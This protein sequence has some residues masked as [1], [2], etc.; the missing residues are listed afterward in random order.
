MY[1]SPLPAQPPHANDF[2]ATCRRIALLTALFLVHASAVQAQVVDYV[3]KPGDNPWDFARQHLNP[4]LVDTLI[5]YNGIKDP[6]HIPPGTVIRIPDSWL[7]RGSRQV[8]VLDVAGEASRVIGKENVVPLKAGERIPAR[9]RILTSSQGSVTL[10]FSDG[11]RMLIREHS[12]VRLQ[13]NKFVPLA[14]GR[15]IRINIP[16]GK[17]ESDVSKH[18]TAP[19]RFEIQ[20]PSGV[21][22]VRGTQ[23]RVASL[24]NETRT[25]VL[26]GKV[27]VGNKRGVFTGLPSGFG[28]SMQKG[29]G[30]GI[31]PLLKAPHIS[32]GTLLVERLPIDLP[33]SPVDGA[34]GYRTLLS[35][36][37]R[38]SA[39]FSDQRR[40]IAA[41]RISDVPDG[42]YELRVRAID[43][44]ELEGEELVRPIT[45]NA[46]PG[47]PF[48][49]APAAEA[50]LSATRPVFT[51][52]RNAEAASYRFQLASNVEFTPL[53]I[54]EPGLTESKYQ[55]GNDLV[56]GR[57][58][59]RPATIS[60]NEG[61]G[62]YSSPDTFLRTPASPGNVGFS[63]DQQSLRWQR[64]ANARYRVQIG[65]A[66][67]IE[68]PLI[69]TVLEQNTLSMTTLDAGNY[70]VRIQTLSESGLT[71]QWTEVQSFT[72]ESR[73][74]WRYLLLPLP[75]LLI[76]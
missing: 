9:S 76:L 55:P 62:P 50:S 61:Q 10:Q 31:I 66:A 40:D 70:F 2:R 46:R 12:D 36:S 44:H 21:A 73:F 30:N 72:V 45:I 57:Y 23:F 39:I 41:M 43:S 24:A 25:E 27:A 22:A 75:F 38:S 51:W 34:K 54:D 3:I 49:I 65:T 13:T 35:A 1:F 19:G 58:Y 56:E 5:E 8:T 11:S 37:A 63:S 59:W 64:I 67:T 14:E 4:G 16:Q 32:E 68:N 18:R 74:D 26:E 47:A 6:H 29:R 42:N 52:A 15:D 53:L 33:I 28:M 69:D 20:T 71:S 17:V 48:P 60:T 7:Y